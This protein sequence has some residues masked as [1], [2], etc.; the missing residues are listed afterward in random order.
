MFDD[1]RDTLRTFGARLD[2]DERRRMATGMRDALVH[3]K[4]ALQYL[5]AG[6]AGTE[7]RLKAEQAELDT[8]RRRQGYAAE[9]GDNETVAIAERFAAQHAERVAMLETKRM[10]QQQ[11]L[12]L[13]ERDYEDMTQELRRVMSGMAPSASTP[14]QE[15]QREVEAALSD[16]P[17]ALLDL[18]STPPPSRRSRAEREADAE[19]RLADLKRKLGR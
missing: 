10:A 9:I 12:H 16:D 7:A 18:D 19:A 4:M 5:R 11:E 6:L 17:D 14:E 15:A 1:L 13:A 2:P 3:A 8:V